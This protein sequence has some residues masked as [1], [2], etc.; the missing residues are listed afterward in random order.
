MSYA[1]CVVD[2]ARQEQ[3]G[4]RIEIKH[5]KK[6]LSH[7]PT[8]QIMRIE[9]QIERI[10]VQTL[11]S[12]SPGNR[13]DIPRNMAASSTTRQDSPQSTFLKKT[14]LMQKKKA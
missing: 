9:M 2:R 14:S 10:R 12:I 6:P 13:P 4:D 7:G 8:L 1:P 3:N 5:L 11:P